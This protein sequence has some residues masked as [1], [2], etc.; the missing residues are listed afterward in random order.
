LINF[1]RGA[2][3]RFVIPLL[4]QMHVFAAGVD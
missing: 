2:K 3:S 4:W 1:I